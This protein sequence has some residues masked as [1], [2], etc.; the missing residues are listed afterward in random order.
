MR[1]ILAIVLAVVVIVGLL[2]C[3]GFD[4]LYKGFSGESQYVY[5]NARSFGMGTPLDL[6]KDINYNQANSYRITASML[7]YFDSI[8]Q[9]YYETCLVENKIVV[10]QDAVVSIKNGKYDTEYKKNETDFCEHAENIQQSNIMIKGN[11]KNIAQSD[12]GKYV[13]VVFKDDGYDADG[14]VIEGCYITQEY[15][16]EKDSGF[17][18]EIIS[19]LYIDNKP[20]YQTNAVVTFY[21]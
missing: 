18:Y 17:I 7:D 21:Q 6:S 15:H 12:E 4:E 9:H 11:Y 5:T 10:D 20:M 1:K 19:M 2:T 16:L 3:L 8:E 14:N 13:R